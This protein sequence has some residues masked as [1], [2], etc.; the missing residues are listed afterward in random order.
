MNTKTRLT[1]AA[2]VIAA[3]TAAAPAHANLSVSGSV[4]GAPSGVILDNLNW[5]T[6]GSAGGLSPQSGIT[7]NFSGNAQAVTGAVGGQYAAPF[8]SG[9]NGTGFGSPNQANGVDATVYATSGSTG[10]SLPAAVEILLPGNGGA[11]YQYFGL[12]WGSVDGY[13]TLSFYDGANLV[14]SLTGSGVLGSPNGDQGVNGTLYVNISSDVAFNRVVATSSQY[15]FEFDNL[16]FNRTSVP[17]P[18]SLALLGLGLAG[19]GFG[20]RRAMG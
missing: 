11:G 6:T 20:R 13:N 2:A 12:L 8:L 14:G 9:G 15:A 3:L 10:A 18:G 7:V 5:L 4:G 1:L 16:A 19:L 17:E